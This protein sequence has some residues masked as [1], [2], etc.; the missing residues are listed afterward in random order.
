MKKNIIIIFTL[1][2]TI[3]YAQ[4]DV[5]I[6]LIINDSVVCMKKKQESVKLSVSIININY[7]WDDTLYLEWFDKY[8]KAD[9]F[10]FNSKKLKIGK[11]LIYLIEDI[12][13]EII[14]VNMPT[15]IPS[16]A[17]YLDEINY[18]KLKY[19][20]DTNELRIRT[21]NKLEDFNNLNISD[22]VCNVN[23]FPLIKRYHYLEKGEYFISLLY[24]NNMFHI[25][26]DNTLENSIRSNKIKL[27][28]K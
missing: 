28:V 1:L 26:E 13:G 6:N 10:F 9:P 16:F 8:P 17:N 4:K 7:Q 20:V 14:L 3:V 21:K 18:A 11:G 27:V 2:N 15:S 23:I 19:Y 22:S 25:G 24:S 5:S 12:Q